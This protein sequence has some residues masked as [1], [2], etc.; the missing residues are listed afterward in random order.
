MI[1]TNRPTTTTT[2]MGNMGMVL[3][4]WRCRVEGGPR[5]WHREEEGEM[6]NRREV[7]E[8]VWVKIAAPMSNGRSNT[9]TSLDLKYPHVDT[10]N[11]TK[12]MAT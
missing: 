4:W 8:Q 11:N 2:T 3:G 5:L 1:M 12:T 10:L 7:H 6:H 9:N